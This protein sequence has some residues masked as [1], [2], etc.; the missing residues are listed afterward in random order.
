M[1]NILLYTRNL[2]YEN[3]MINYYQKF[4]FSDY[5]HANK[6]VVSGYK[7]ASMIVNYPSK[8]FPNK[9]ISLIY[10]VQESRLQVYINHNTAYDFSKL[11]KYKLLLSL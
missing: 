7:D 2:R 3:A 4:L 11:I 8:V 5:I 1:K 9:M 10:H 6:I